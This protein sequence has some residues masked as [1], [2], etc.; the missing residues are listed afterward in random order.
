MFTK[1][2]GSK[3]NKKSVKAKCSHDTIESTTP[4]GLRVQLKLK[5]GSFSAGNITVAETSINN[6]ILRIPLEQIA[7]PGKC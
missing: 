4:N 5:S 2:L 7:R 6:R 3:G 1:N